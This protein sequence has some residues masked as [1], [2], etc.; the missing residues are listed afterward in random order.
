MEPAKVIRI[1]NNVVHE[2]IEMFLKKRGYNSENTATEYK[3]DIN[4]FFNIVKGKEIHFLNNE[5]VQVTL[6]DFEKFIAT[7]HGELNNKTINR[8]VSSVKQVLRYLHSKKITEDV[9]YLEQ[10]DRLPEKE[11]RHG[12]LTVDEVMQMAE[13]ARTTERKYKEVKYFL[14]LFALDTCLRKTAILN[15]KWSDFVERED[16]VLVKAV[17]KGNSDARLKISQK[18][19]DE[20]KSLK[21]ENEDKVFYISDQAVDDMM[22]RLR[23]KMGIKEERRIVFHSLRKT[24]VSFQYRI[25][26]NDILQA[27]KAARH[28]RVETTLLYLD[29][30]DYGAS[31]AISMGKDLD[32]D[33]YKKVDHELL[34]ETISEMKNFQLL[35]NIKLKEKL[36]KL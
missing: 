31:G 25:S 5:D 15:L 30:E 7:L 2:Q 21:K 3:R 17:D 36:E 4:K 13:L 8:A 26:G 29:E 33:L 35:L 19:F 6:D 10:V 32:K 11:N 14:L 20:L 1:N 22:I 16:G 9:G 12:I 23:E 24:G 18:F 28:K 27:K 34:L